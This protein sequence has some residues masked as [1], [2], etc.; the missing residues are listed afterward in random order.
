MGNS[1]SCAPS[2]TSSRAVKVVCPDG[3]IAVFT[4]PTNAAELMLENPSRFVCDA[5]DLKVGHRIPGLAA[6][7][8][9][10]PRHLYFLLPMTMLHSILTA[11]DML[12]LS[13]KASTVIKRGGP[14]KNI[15]RIFPVFSDSCIFQ[16]EAKPLPTPI[17]HHEPNKRFSRHRSWKP[18][19]DTID[20]SPSS[21]EFA[22]NN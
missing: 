15:G 21:L 14:S 5:A 19:L 6:D 10:E 4:G 8:E 13:N 18:A 7:E 22:T 11:A 3:R 20:E 9:L 12:S 16:S 2:T 17:Q 1:I